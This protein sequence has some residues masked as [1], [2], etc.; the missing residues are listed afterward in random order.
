VRIT[1]VAH[2]ILVYRGKVHKVGE[3][4]FL[5]LGHRFPLVLRAVTLP[6]APACG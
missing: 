3:Q 2:A 4:L 5:F 6:P 1:L